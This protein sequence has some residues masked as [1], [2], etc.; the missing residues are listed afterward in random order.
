MNEPHL[1]A[2]SVWPA[3]VG[4]G[5]TMMAFGVVTSLYFS[6]AG[7]VVLALGLLGWIEELRHE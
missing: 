7:V 6:A 5:V 4:A 2:P 1:P 3:T